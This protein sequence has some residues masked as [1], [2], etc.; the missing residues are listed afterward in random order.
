[1]QQIKPIQMP[2]VLSTVAIISATVTVIPIFTGTKSLNFIRNRT[3]GLT[4]RAPSPVA[5]QVVRTSSKFRKKKSR[6]RKK[7][8]IY[9]PDRFRL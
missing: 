5:F 6:M 9:P 2:V 8:I 4:S 3:R 1:M 7:A